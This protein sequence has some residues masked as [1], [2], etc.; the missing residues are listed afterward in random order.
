MLTVSSCTDPVTLVIKPILFEKFAVYI[1]C[2]LQ[3]H[4]PFIKC[5]YMTIMVFYISNDESTYNKS[6]ELKLCIAITVSQ[7]ASGVLLVFIYMW[8]SLSKFVKFC[9]NNSSK[10]GCK[11]TTELCRGRNHVGAC[12]KIYHFFKDIPCTSFITKHEQN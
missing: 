9:I 1:E 7:Q 5:A 2:L 11:E 8:F 12:R 4:N 3:N 10:N 6:I